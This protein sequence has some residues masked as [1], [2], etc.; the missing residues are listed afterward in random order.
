MTDMLQLSLTGLPDGA[1]VLAFV[2]TEAISRPYAL[3]VHLVATGDVSSFDPEALVGSP[4]AL[5]VQGAEGAK[6]LVLA[7]IVDAVDVVLAVDELV[8]FKVSVGPRLGRLAAGAHSR[9]WIQK[10]FPQVLEELLVAGGVDR[11][12]VELQASYPTLEHLCQYHESDLDFV[13]RRMERDGIYYWFEHAEDGETL[14]VSDQPL[15]HEARP[16]EAVPF[17]G[18]EELDAPGGAREALYRFAASRTLAPE[19]VRLADYDYLH[20]SLEVANSTAVADGLAGHVVTFGGNLA[21]PADASRLATV[22]SE[23]LTARA[24]RYV[25]HGSALGLSAGYTFELDEHPVGAMNA[26][27]LVTALHHRGADFG[28]IGTGARLIDPRGEWLGRREE[29]NYRFELEAQR[30]SDPYRPPLR[31]PVPRVHGFERAVV[32]GPAD[33]DYAQLDEHG[34]YHVKVMF[35]ENE[36]DGGKASAWIRMLQPHGGAPEGFHFPLRKGTEVLLSFVAGD[37]DR[38]LIVA[39]GPNPETPSP[40]TKANA[41]QNVIQTGGENRMEIEDQ[42]GQEYVATYSPPEKTT[43]HLGA[44]ASKYHE[45]HNATLRTDGNMRI[46]AGS[47]RHITV[48]GEETED[49]QGPLTEDYH[50]T[51]S[52]HVFGAWDETIDGGATQTISAGETRTVTGGLTEDISGGETRTIAPDQT[53]SVSASRTVIVGANVTET[54]GAS[55]THTV[56]ASQSETIGGSLTQT[57]GADYSVTT[58]ASY[59]VTATGGSTWV[60]PAGFTILAPGGVTTVDDHH[61]AA[62]GEEHASYVVEMFWCFSLGDAA[63]IFLE[64]IGTELDVSLFRAYHA[65][66]FTHNHANHLKGFGM[67]LTYG[68]CSALTAG[69]L[70]YT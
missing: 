35:D 30:A 6:R 34:R 20:P 31:T 25:G 32:D 16:A 11:Y 29:G 59:T 57:V 50:A 17:H 33:S 7:G 47:D 49:V 65:T 18:A 63:G 3:E 36:A 14:H 9:V 22:R 19:N 1:R 15:A 70:H 2:A 12:E 13:S 66:V 51:Q 5:T 54:V 52:T 27:Y 61:N 62:G 64:A 38:P 41:T 40:V 53:E 46:H 8:R 37:A 58:P 10:T 21:T 26:S 68:I 43:L 28:Q 69:W 56:G 4:A 45:G 42:A 55:A 39:T 23:E 44:H 48:G 60:A 67:C 24:R